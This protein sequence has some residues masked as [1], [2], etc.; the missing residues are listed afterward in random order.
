MNRPLIHGVIA[1]LLLF[2]HAVLANSN[3]DASA[4]IYGSPGLNSVPSARMYE[5]GTVSIGASTLDPYMHGFLGFQI[6]KPLFIAVRQSAEASS[7]GGDADRLYPGVDVKLRLVEEG[8]YRPD[9]SIGIQSAFGHKRMA[10]EYLALSKRYQNFDFT[11]GLGWGRYGTAGHFN[12]PLKSISG[13][14]GKSRD[15]N[16][17]ISNSAENWFTGE[18]IGLFG[19]IEYFTPITGLSL[20]A[21]Y[22]S[23]RYSA[24]R[25]A[26]N[27]S[28]PAPWSIGL[29]YRP[30]DWVDAAIGMQGTDKI[31]ARVNLKSIPSKWPF[32]QSHDVNYAPISPVRASGT[33]EISN[34]S[35]I[36]N[37]YQKE[38][39]YLASLD[40]R[41][42][43]N[44]PAQLANASAV[45]ANSASSEV[46]SISIQPTKYNLSGPR[47]SI[48][49]RDLEM[50][51][52]R[53][54]GSAD[55]IWKNTEFRSD[56]TKEGR[57]KN[58][59][60][61]LKH[62]KFVL[63]N[64]ISLSEE[65]N[66]TLYRSSL[67]ANMEGPS[68][69]GL[70]HSG[71][72][73]RLNLADNLDHIKDL[74]PQVIFPVRGNV[75]DFADRRIALENSYLTYTKSFTPSLHLA[76]TGGYLEEMYAGGGGEILYRPFD[77]RF[78]V[79][80][81]AWLAFKRS[82][83]DLLNLKLNGDSVLTGHLNAWYDFPEP[84]LTLNARVGRYLAEDTGATLALKK[85]FINGAS[86]EAFATYT[87]ASD[88]DLFGGDT[89]AYH[90][91]RLAMPLGSIK[92]IPNGSEIRLTAA[93]FG[94]ETGQ[95]LN[96][97]FDLYAE[98]ESFSY[99][100]IAR[101]W[102]QITP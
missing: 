55:E 101:Y 94:R 86:L 79:G 49:R 30:Y 3:N 41:S 52:G 20:K 89:H 68:F 96:K 28:A 65:D 67:I 48:N 54:Q 43:Q 92:Y 10:G 59:P 80:A 63:D 23:D 8:R 35:A 47:I 14:F 27:Y 69:L 12:N 81:D 34:N 5:E 42:N 19:G 45:L 16:G 60:M 39:T 13:H 75:Y 74:R 26:F 88:F 9:L 83:D 15:L 24:E 82:P 87:N 91:V 72:A 61:L 29:N 62:F 46:E 71:T 22:G 32:K 51:R 93:P 31:M 40:L 77:S 85:G 73:L 78:A 17:E 95:S 57:N 38:R 53:N 58:S 98:T 70:I 56:E 102:H 36:Y 99:D 7:L 90:G 84:D 6:A 50:A 76:M 21:D 18:S 64:Q 44:T 1:G 37:I 33:R 2:P 11:A 4:N 100:H 97:P 25:A 66:G